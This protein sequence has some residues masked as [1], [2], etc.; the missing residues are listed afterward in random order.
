M[1]FGDLAVYHVFK[2]SVH[3]ILSTTN[4][5]TELWK[6]CE[7]KGTPWDETFLILSILTI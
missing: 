6:R 4:S 3:W 7:F 1:H 2:S 5:F